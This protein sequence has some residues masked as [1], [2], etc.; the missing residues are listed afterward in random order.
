MFTRVLSSVRQLHR[1]FLRAG[2][3]VI[4]AFTFA[5]D[6]GSEVDE[7]KLQQVCDNRDSFLAA[8]VHSRVSH[9]VRLSLS[10]GSKPWLSLGV[11]RS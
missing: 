5:L 2:A 6:S 1:E 7:G 9:I 11:S 8:T 3:D 4:Q 10:P